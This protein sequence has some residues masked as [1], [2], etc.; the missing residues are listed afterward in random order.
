M[1]P[2]SVAR[3]RQCRLVVVADQTGAGAR[4]LAALAYPDAATVQVLDWDEPGE[5]AL[6]AALASGT[7]VVLDAQ[8]GSDALL[9]RL[10]EGAHRADGIVVLVRR[11]AEAPRSPLLADGGA[12]LGV[13]HVEAV[14]RFTA[15]EVLALASARGWICRAPT[16]SGCASG[17]QDSSR[18]AWRCSTMRR[19]PAAST[20]TPCR[21]VRRSASLMLCARWRP[22]GRRNPMRRWRERSRCSGGAPSCRPVR[23][24]DVL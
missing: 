4:E 20:R 18:S 14:D 13:Q 24:R 15:D 2:V 12:A 17:R 8:R 10:A 21:R 22:G 9:R 3:I 5:A 19:A 7:V 23:S 16:R 6:A 1:E 11:M